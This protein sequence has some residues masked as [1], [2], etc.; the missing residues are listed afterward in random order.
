MIIHVVTLN[1]HVKSVCVFIFY[2]PHI[3]I[4]GVLDLVVME[5]K[6]AGHPLQQIINKLLFIVS[7]TLTF[8][9]PDL[10]VG[11]GPVL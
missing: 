2:L 6:V 8:D 11:T 3:Y 1:V 4:E 5:G 9:I 10:F 7:N